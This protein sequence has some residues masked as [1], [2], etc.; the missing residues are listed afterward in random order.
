MDRKAHWENIY[1]TKLL[2]E[3]S[4][5]QPQPSFSFELI[6]KYSKGKDAKIIDVGGGDSFLVDKLLEEGYTD[7]TVLDISAK[8]IERAQERLGSRAD[9]VK[10]ICSDI[11]ELNPT[12]QYDIW[13]DRAA[14][15]FMTSEQDV[16]AY[17]KRLIEATCAGS[18]LIVGTFSE[19]G[20]TKCSG[21]EIHQYSEKDLKETFSPE[22]ELLDLINID[23][24]TPF[25]TLQNFNFGIFRRL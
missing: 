21:I 8:A 1:Q 4:W 12:E 14:F 16:E 9:R 22:F 23:H 10:W 13:Y 25:G 6:E 2:T 3:V 24:T 11:S 5:Y 15:H 19:N 17:K 7:L 20:P 18:I